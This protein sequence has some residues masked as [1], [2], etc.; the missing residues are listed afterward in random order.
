YESVYEWLFRKTKPGGVQYHFIDLVDHRYYFGTGEFNEWSFLSEETGPDN[1][2]RLRVSEHRA[3]LEQAGF[4]IIKERHKSKAIPEEARET[5][6]PP[7]S[8]M[9]DTEI[10]TTKMWCLLRRPA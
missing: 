2:N 9:P 10:N 5:L 1:V 6:L 8:D 7:W 3:L 4:E